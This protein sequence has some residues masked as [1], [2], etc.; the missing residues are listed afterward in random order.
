MFRSEPCSW[1][2]PAT[3]GKFK[4]TAKE[5]ET[6]EEKGKDESEAFHK[7]VPASLKFMPSLLHRK[8]FNWHAL[9]SRYS[10]QNTVSTA[11][12]WAAALH[13]SPGK[14]GQWRSQPL[15]CP[16]MQPYGA[17]RRLISRTTT[18]AAAHACGLPIC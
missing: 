1:N 6:K 11:S 16:T 2:S 15:L 3:I 12:Q 7:K 5:C 9:P 18:A 17:A 14:E 10:R 8:Q 13:E 4:S